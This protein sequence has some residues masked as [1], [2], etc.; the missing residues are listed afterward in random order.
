MSVN[1]EYVAPF[2]LDF[3]PSRQFEADIP[4]DLETST[5]ILA[6]N[7][8]RVLMMGWQD[9]T[10]LA[11][12]RL[13]S[14]LAIQHDSELSRA[15]RY[16][17][18]QGFDHIYTQLENQELTESQFNQA[19][20]FLSNCLMLLPFSDITP[21]ESFNIPQHLQGK[22]QLVTYKVTPIELTPT[23]GFEQ[24]FIQDEDRVFA[25]GLEPITHL[26][27][28]P[29]LIF[30]GTTYPSGQG[31]LT[32]INT[33]MEPFE[34]VGKKLYRTGHAKIAAWLDKQTQKTHVCGASLGGSLS[35]LLAIHQ[36]EK[37]SRVDALN[38]PGLYDPWRKSRFDRWD[39]CESKPS[40]YIQKQANDVVSALGVWKDDWHIFQVTPPID[41]AGPLPN[42]DHAL[43]YAGLA[44]TRF[45][46][47]DAHTDNQNRRVRNFFIYVVLRSLAYYL[48]MVPF[49]YVIYPIIHYLVNHKTQVALIGAAGALVLI[50]PALAVPMTTILALNAIVSASV[51]GTFVS[52]IMA[53]ITDGLSSKNDSAMSHFIHWLETQWI[54]TKAFFAVGLLAMLIIPPLIISP[55]I[56][57]GIFYLWLSIPSAA[58]LSHKIIQVIRTLLHLNVTSIP[59]C[60]SP[61]LPRN[62]LLDTYKNE[63]EET[64]TRKQFSDYRRALNGMENEG[65]F[66][67]EQTD[68][69]QEILLE[70]IQETITITASKA[71]IHDIRQTIRL[72]NKI[73]FHQPALLNDRL[74]QKHHDYTLGNGSR[75]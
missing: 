66:S 64:F 23:T 17:F 58:L 19:Q 14:A 20:F 26:D 22:W 30:M 60:H 46:P 40:V 28:E 73:G 21:Y 50:F 24:L 27:A 45:E 15:M 55:A 70:G 10:S 5:L 43:N 65:L 39:F 34:T 7:L 41:K 52:I 74:I 75:K 49:R 61:D 33:D 53:Y 62:E 37:L 25:Y 32:Q 9:S 4:D 36:G 8:L 71:K 31:F 57:S 56:A 68:L 63:I 67:E 38:P 48:G 13:L 16:A 47:I 44:G 69:E 54:L 3:F 72:V 1:K 51:I 29:H 18:Q 11:S 35:L 2:K 59:H 6:R 42:I 12:L